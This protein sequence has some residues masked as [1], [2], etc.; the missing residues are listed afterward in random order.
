MARRSRAVI[1]WAARRVLVLSGKEGGAA[2]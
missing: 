1:G 2:S